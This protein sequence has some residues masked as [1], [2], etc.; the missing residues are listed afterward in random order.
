[1]ILSVT[2]SKKH[3]EDILKKKYGYNICTVRRFCY[4]HLGYDKTSLEKLLTQHE[5]FLLLKRRIV[6]K[7]EE[8]LNALYIYITDI[9]ENQHYGN[10]YALRPFFERY[11]LRSAPEFKKEI[12][13]IIY[14]E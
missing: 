8:D 5:G 10:M 7:T 2:V 11:A 4:N 1:M 13:N 9:I 12:L 3:I 6:W 14:N